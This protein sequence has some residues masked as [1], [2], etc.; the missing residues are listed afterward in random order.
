MHLAQTKQQILITGNRFIDMFR[1]SLCY[2]VDNSLERFS[3]DRILTVEFRRNIY[4]YET[5]EYI[6]NNTID[7][8]F[9]R[10]NNYTAVFSREYENTTFFN[11]LPIHE[12]LLLWCYHDS[13]WRNDGLDRFLRAYE[14]RI[15]DIGIGGIQVQPINEATQTEF[16]KHLRSVND[17]EANLERCKFI[18]ELMKRG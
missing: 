15:T 6:V 12:N 7:L 5:R 2:H 10:P 4:D 13:C 8:V 16:R 18:D 17:R 14:S 3:T 11:R 1:Q 9:Y